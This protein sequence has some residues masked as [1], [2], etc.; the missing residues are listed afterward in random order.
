MYGNYDLLN[1]LPEFDVY[2]GPNYWDT[3]KFNSSAMPVN[4]EMI[5]MSTSDYI[6]V[7]LLNTGRGTPFVSAI[8]LRLLESNMYPQTDLGSLYVYKYADYGNTGELR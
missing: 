8:E 7:C 4:M 6:H 5:H 3:L 2:L 1:I